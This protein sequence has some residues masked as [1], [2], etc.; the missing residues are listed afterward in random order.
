[1]L[2]PNIGTFIF[3]V[4]GMIINSFTRKSCVLCI[5]SHHSPINQEN[6]GMRWLKSRAYEWN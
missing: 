1:M 5:N 6:I 2:T 3:K 4:L